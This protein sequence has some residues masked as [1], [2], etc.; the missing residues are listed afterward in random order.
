SYRS[1]PQPPIFGGMLS[2]FESVGLGTPYR[3]A[4][5]DLAE[6]IF[7]IPALESPFLA[8]SRRCWRVPVIGRAIR[9]T[10]YRLVDRL[11]GS[12]CEF[13]D[14]VISGV[15]LRGDVSHWMLTGAYFANEEYEPETT[16]YLIRHL[17]DGG[18]FVDV[19]ANAGLMTLVAAARVGSNGRV[20]AF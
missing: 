10:G 4:T 12:G 8:I 15:P 9:S 3:R 2:F 5:G 11:R 19:G 6:L 13:R 7:R 1:C 16:Q 20:L 18:V 14:I 17:P